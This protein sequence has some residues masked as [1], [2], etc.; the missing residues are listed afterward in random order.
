[1]EPNLYKTPSHETHF[2]VS[3]GGKGITAECAV[4]LARAFQSSFTLIGSSQLLNAEPD[5]AHGQDQEEDLKK[6][7][8]QF[9]QTKDIKLSPKEMDRE[10]RQILSSREIR[11]TINRISEA[12]GKAHY[13]QADITDLKELEKQLDP[14]LS[15]INALVHGAGALADK[16]IEDKQEADY[17]LVYG[18]K[19]K[20]LK[21]ILSLVSPTQLDSIV[22]FSSVAGYYGNPGQADYSLSNEILNKYAHHINQIHPSCRILA[23]N[24]GPWDGGMVSPQLKRI[25]IKKNIRLISVEEGTDTLIELL[26][27]PDHQPQWVVGNPMPL[28]AT[29]ISDELRTFRISRKLTMEA[30]PFLEDHVIGGQ[31]VLPTVCAVGWFVNSCEKLYPGFQFYSIKDYRVFKGIIFDQTLA[32]K[33]LLELD[34]IQKSKDVLLFQGKISSESPQAKIRNHYQ[35][36]IELR[37]YIPERSRLEDFDITPENSLDGEHFYREKILFHG[38]RF[39]GVQEVLNL[40]PNGLTTRCR[41]NFIPPDE[42][43]QFPVSSFNPYLADIH[44]QSLLLWA[45]AQ[46]NSIGLPLSIAGGTQYQP[47]LFDTT[48]YATMRVKSSSNHKLVADVISH[49][50][51]GYIFS[52]VTDAEITLNDKLFDLFKNN[53]LVKE[54]A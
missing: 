11:R 26:S 28:P 21:N 20:G 52:Y 9:Y 25:L 41:L 13:L 18:V 10:L 44:L 42:Q 38:P 46:K 32:N 19:V 4:A 17:E 29:P 12:G 54:Q 35:A 5:W 43:G 36:Q 22:L 2:L 16:H 24:W 31:A 1:M 6:A 40:T 53:K 48:T 27:T 45:N 14:Y 37:K 39:Q 8:L 34:E 50:E 47:I 33:Y 49:D 7:L 30:N 51:A 23:I 3:G 15:N